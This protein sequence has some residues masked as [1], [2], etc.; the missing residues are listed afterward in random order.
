MATEVRFKFQP[1]EAIAKKKKPEEMK[2]LT[3]KGGMRGG[4]E[5]CGWGEGEARAIGCRSMSA[6]RSL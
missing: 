4:K 3:R 1:D 5:R 2:M 6:V